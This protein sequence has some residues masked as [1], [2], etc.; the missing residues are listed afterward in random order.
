[1]V[2][3]KD[4]LSL[5]FDPARERVLRESTGQERFA[6]NLMF[7]LSDPSLGISMWLH[8]GT[9]PDDFGMWEDYIQLHLPDGAGTLW[10]RSYARVPIDQRP[11]GANLKAQC[12]EPWRRWRLTFDGVVTRTPPEELRTGPACD[13][14]REW[15][16]F[17]L[18]LTMAGPVWDAHSSAESKHG[19][20]SMG[21]QVW[22]KDHYQQLYTVAGTITFDEKTTPFLGSGVRD[23]S[24]GQR[25]LRT[26]QFE[27]HA[28]ISALYPSGKGFG[29]QRVW[30]P[31]GRITLDTA[32]VYIDGQYEFASVVKCPRIGRQLRYAGESLELVLRSEL[33]EHR[34]TG[35]L[36]S[37][38]FISFDNSGMGLSIGA[39]PNNPDGYFAPGFARWDWDGERAIG[40]TERSERHFN[41]PP[42]VV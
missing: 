5:G 10:S 19:G 36:V 38:G 34:L 9:W 17:D 21:E 25:G 30:N 27:G 6:E 2:H 8:L 4:D 22:A 31:E 23:H 37:S 35:E 26:D 39:R 40:L 15:F 28:L 42:E 3:V 7:A 18:E 13:G 1:M 20:G 11:A 12:L 32:F 29:M 16:Q 33:G 14:P 41:N 24:R